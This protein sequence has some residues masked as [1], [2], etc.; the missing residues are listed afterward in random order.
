MQHELE[1]KYK[2][3]IFGIIAVIILGTMVTFFLLGKSWLGAGVWS[4][5]FVIDLLFTLSSINRVVIINIEDGRV[6]LNTKT[7]IGKENLSFHIT[8]LE[9]LFYYKTS[10]NFIPTGKSLKGRFN[11]DNNPSEDIEILPVSGMTGY[12]SNQQRLQVIELL[13]QLNPKIVLGYTP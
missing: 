4:I 3:S 10:I 9:R 12:L 5:P 7:L 6:T 11:I 2:P 1:L 8:R 13:L